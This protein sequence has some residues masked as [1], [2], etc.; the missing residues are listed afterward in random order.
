[1]LNPLFSC[2]WKRRKS[3]FDDHFWLDMLDSIAQCL[4]SHYL[5]P[6]GQDVLLTVR[7]L[8]CPVRNQKTQAA[9]GPPPQTR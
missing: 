2:P 4:P 1:M 9:Y 7:F 6:L 5:I 3:T 8:R